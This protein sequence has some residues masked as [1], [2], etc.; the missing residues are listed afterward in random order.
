MSVNITIRN[1]VKRYG[2]NVV[3]PNLSWRSGKV[4]SLRSWVPAAAANHSPAHDRG[5]QHH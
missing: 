5:F 2:D 3:I 4:S 1:A